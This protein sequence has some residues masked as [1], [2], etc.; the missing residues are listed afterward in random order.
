[1]PTIR[2]LALVSGVGIAA[3]LGAACVAQEPAPDVAAQAG[4]TPIP[5]SERVVADRWG[6]RVQ[7]RLKND[8]DQMRSGALEVTLLDE[9]G[10]VVGTYGAIVGGVKPGEEVTYTALGGDRPGAWGRVSVRVT[11]QFVHQPRPQA[12]G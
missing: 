1:M 9:A 12:A 5:E 7:G 6:V 3:T 2:R 11:G 10:R 8:S 4:L